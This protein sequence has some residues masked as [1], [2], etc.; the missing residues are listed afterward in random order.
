[1][2]Q[3]NQLNHESEIKFIFEKVEYNIYDIIFNWVSRPEYTNEIFVK[4][5]NRYCPDCFCLNHFSLCFYSF[6][7]V[8]CSKVLNPQ[9]LIL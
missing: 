6:L 2:S 1:M 8:Y 4:I 3:F 9:F 7:V 5:V